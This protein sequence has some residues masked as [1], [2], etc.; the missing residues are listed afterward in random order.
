M[1]R[2]LGVSEENMRVYEEYLNEE[3]LRSVPVL[4]M[5]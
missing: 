2:I 3:I 5:Y 1:R 4:G